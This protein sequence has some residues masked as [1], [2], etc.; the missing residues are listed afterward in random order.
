MFFFL[1][2]G[3]G[4]PALQ[5][6]DGAAEDRLWLGGQFLGLDL[7][8]IGLE[9][10]SPSRGGSARVLATPHGQHVDQDRICVRAP[11]LAGHIGEWIAAQ[12]FDIRLHRVFSYSI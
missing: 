11:A 12:I 3:G 10:D 8:A 4:R 5:D 2:A 7:F 9:R 6:L 1:V